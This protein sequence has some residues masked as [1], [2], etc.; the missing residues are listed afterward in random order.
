MD[1]REC[2]YDERQLTEWLKTHGL[3]PPPVEA[4]TELDSLCRCIER[5]G[6]HHLEP[7]P[8]IEQVLWQSANR[9]PVPEP[10]V[11]FELLVER[12]RL[13]STGLGRGI[14]VP[15]PRS[16]LEG[17]APAPTIGVFYPTEPIRMGA[18][19]GQPV[20][21]L[22]VLLSPT[23]R[24]H[25]QVLSRL[26]YCLKDDDFIGFLHS[27]PGRAALCT[28]LEDLDSSLANRAVGR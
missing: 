22:F 21:A 25:L 7:A 26:A 4:P 13:A 11:L 1:G 17:I 6:V 14:A 5:G 10:R 2:C 18:I 8:D 23:V 3:L 20:F 12:E 16:P 27:R 9:L 28:R 19:D 15:H 24:L